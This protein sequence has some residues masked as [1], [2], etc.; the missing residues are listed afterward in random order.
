MHTYGEIAPIGD[1]LWFHNYSV[2]LCA[3]YEGAPG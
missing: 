3:V 2:V 1:A